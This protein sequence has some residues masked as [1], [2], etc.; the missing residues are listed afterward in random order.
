MTQ[1]P[2][3]FGACLPAVGVMD[4]LRFQKFTEGRAV[5]R[6]L[7]LGGRQ[8]R[9]VQGPAGLFAHHNIQPGTC[10]PPTLVTTADTDDRVVPGHS[11]KF[12]AAMQRAQSCDKPVLIEISTPPAT[13]ALKPTEDIAETADLWAFLVKS[14]GMK[15]E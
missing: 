12:T 10:Y 2:D 11:F 4:M 14:L 8:P 1:R 5:G 15:V 9:G 6:R 13:A 7:R 3:L